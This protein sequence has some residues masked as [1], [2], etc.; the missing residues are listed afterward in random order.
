MEQRPS[1][2]QNWLAF[3]LDGQDFAVEL[4]RVLEIVPLGD[5]HRLP[6]APGYVRGTTLLRGSTLLAI[7]LRMALGMKG[8]MALTHELLTNFRQRKQDHIRWLQELERSVREA[9][10][11]GLSL[12]PEKCAFGRWYD[13]YEAP[14]AV[15]GLKLMQFDRP[16]RT[17]HAVGGEALRLTSQGQQAEAFALIERTRDGALSALVRLFDET[18]QLLVGTEK[19]VVI[20]LSNGARRVGLVVDE[21]KGIRGGEPESFD[22]KVYGA[23]HVRHGWMKGLG[24]IESS[25]IGVFLDGTL[26]VE[27]VTSSDV[28]QD[29]ITT[30]AN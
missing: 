12:D 14:N 22:E 10:P 23:R 20:V 11:F 1:S 21:V 9:K 7:D 16:H 2:V 27:A 13:R 5:V 15:I 8:L 25:R 6:N 4:E 19:E 3:K 29:P 17:I 18:E 26:L 28:D 24:V 30:P